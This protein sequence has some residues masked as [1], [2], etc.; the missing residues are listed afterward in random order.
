MVVMQCHVLGVVVVPPLLVA[1]LADVR[2]RRRRD[3]R[4]GPAVGAGAGGP[5]DHRGRLPAA[6]RLRAPARLRGDARRSSPTSAAAAGAAA[7]GALARIGIVGARSIA[8]PVLRRV[9]RPAAARDPGRD[10]RDRPGGASPFWPVAGPAGAPRRGSPGPSRG[11]SSRSRC[12][13][14]ASRSDHP[15]PAQ[16][17]LPLVPRPARA[18][19]ARRGAGPGRRARDGR[20]GAG[21]IGVGAGRSDGGRRGASA[22][23]SSPSA[24]SRG[25]PRRRPTGAGGSPTRPRR[26]RSTAT[27]GSAVPPRR[28]PAVQ[29]RQR[30]ALPARASRRAPPCLTGPPASRPARSSSSATR[31]STTSSALPAV[32]RRRMRCWRHGELPASSLVDRFDAGRAARDLRLRAGRSEQARSP[33]VDVHVYEGGISEP[34]CAPNARLEAARRSG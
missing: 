27:D 4:V 32:V 3:E 31:C 24:S 30:H 15:G 9:H 16:R 29:E 2:G 23:C 6:A 13:R 17:P 5:R 22:S 8:W 25:H 28:D 18:G 7:S 26:G 34:R 12:S 10:R 14:R 11:R 20:A 19:A 1:W 33:L 21:A